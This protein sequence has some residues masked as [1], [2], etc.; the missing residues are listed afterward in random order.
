MQAFGVETGVSDETHQRKRH[1]LPSTPECTRADIARV[2]A[3]V[4]DIMG[5]V[6]KRHF[7]AQD[8]SSE[9]LLTRT[10]RRYI[11]DYVD[12]DAHCG[13]LHFSQSLTTPWA[14]RSYDEAVGSS[15][16]ATR[17]HFFDAHYYAERYAELIGRP[18]IR[19]PSEEPVDEDARARWHE[20]KELE[21]GWKMTGSWWRTVP[22]QVEAEPSLAQLCARS[23]PP[24]SRTHSGLTVVSL[25]TL[26]EESF[27]QV[28]FEEKMNCTFS[29]DSST[30]APEESIL[31]DSATE[32]T[33]TSGRVTPNDEEFEGPR[34]LTIIPEG[35]EEETMSRA[36]R[37]VCHASGTARGTPLSI[38]LRRV[39]GA[40]IQSDDVRKV[41]DS[42]LLQ[43]RVLD[44]ATKA[45]VLKGRSQPFASA[46]SNRY[47]VMESQSRSQLR[48]GWKS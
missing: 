27:Q 45:D 23:P 34:L 18:H 38:G 39:V 14:K 46:R 41:S 32:E 22:K 30:V 16:E 37:S 10:Q 28:Y 7:S 21:E 43:R 40:L 17:R 6:C 29:C 12:I 25:G 13:R 1:L 26:N 8:L 19:K 48:S 24:L 4:G 33:L 31:D 2:A 44:V 42:K 36:S 35:K 3:R 20:L 15:P 47:A 11:L 5:V 9:S